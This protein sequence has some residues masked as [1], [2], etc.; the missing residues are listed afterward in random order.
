MYKGRLL[1]LSVCFFLSAAAC[2]PQDRKIVTSSAGEYVE[3]PAHPDGSIDKDPAT[4]EP[5]FDGEADYDPNEVALAAANKALAKAAEGDYAGLLIW[6]L[7]GAAAI[8]LGYF[9]RKFLKDAIVK[10][11]KKATGGV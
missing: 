8:G 9:K 10:V 5:V 11:A 1:F 2:T 3:A 4:G 7:G 6:S